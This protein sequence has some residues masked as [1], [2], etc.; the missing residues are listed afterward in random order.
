MNSSLCKAQDIRPTKD[1]IN[2]KFILFFN[3]GVSV[4]ENEYG[5]PPQDFSNSSPPREVY[6]YGLS[7]VHFDVTGIYIPS[8]SMGLAVR[9]GMDINTVS[10]TSRNIVNQYMVGL[11][12]SVFPKQS[13]F[14]LYFLGLTGGVTTNVTNSD[15]SFFEYGQIESVGG[16]DIP[17]FGSGV[18][19]Y[20]GMGLSLNIYKRLCFNLSAGYLVSSI[21]FPNGTVTSYSTNYVTNNSSMGISTQSLQMTIGILQLNCGLSRNL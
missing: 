1:T 21:E 20:G 3:A 16:N 4:P 9:Y 19:L 11:Y 2:R 12:L 7:G 13:N 15:N 8:T 6:G 18:G 17:G 10:V 5:V 14:N